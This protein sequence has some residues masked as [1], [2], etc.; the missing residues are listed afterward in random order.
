MIWRNPLDDIVPLYIYIH[1]VLQAGV[2]CS[3]RRLFRHPAK[4]WC[5]ILVSLENILSA[6]KGPPMKN[7]CKWACSIFLWYINNSTLI[8]FCATDGWADEMW[9]T[10]IRPSQWFPKHESHLG[11]EGGEHS[12]ASLPPP[13]SPPWIRRYRSATA[14]HNVCFLTQQL[15]R[16]DGHS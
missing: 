4:K 12:L 9:T 2:G 8:Q 13:P 3:R 11:L 15:S 1:S 14:L 10:Q 6:S 16:P 7:V 5:G